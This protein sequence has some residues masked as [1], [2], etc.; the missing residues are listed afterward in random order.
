MTVRVGVSRDGDLPLAEGPAEVFGFRPLL[1]WALRKFS[2]KELTRS[3][4]VLICDKST[5]RVT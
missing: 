5:D 2:I 1:N 3:S 4:S